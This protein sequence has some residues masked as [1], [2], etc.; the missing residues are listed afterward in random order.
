MQKVVNVC[1]I[2]TGRAGMIHAKNYNGNVNNAKL[3]ALCDPLEENLQKAQTGLQVAYLYTDYKEALKNE[4]IDAVVVVTPTGLHKEIVIAAAKAKKHVFCEKPMAVT[5]EECDAMISACEENNVKLQIGF[6]RRF[7]ESFKKGKQLIEEGAVGEVTLLKSLTHG[8]S[9]PKEWMYDI[10]KSAGPIGEVNSHDL[11]TLRWYANSEV[12]QIHAIGRNFRSPEKKQQYPEYYDTV[13]ILLEFENGILGM[14]DGAQYVQYGYDSRAE[15][16]GTHGNVKIGTQKTDNVVVAT[17]DKQLQSDAMPSW[18]K[19]F[20]EAYIN[21]ASSFVQCILH[22]T[23]PEVQGN[24]GK[25]ALMLVQ[26]GLRSLLEKRPIR[27]G[28]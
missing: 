28:E 21:E 7:D 3:I 26:E 15:I 4:E 25:K 9:E 10:S 8:P 20:K 17:K 13:A 14:I 2:G 11:D 24:D 19:L 5:T 18:T 12:K 1:L 16:L 6:M 22:N 23:K 27:I